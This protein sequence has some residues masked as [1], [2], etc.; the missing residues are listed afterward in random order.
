MA[1]ALCDRRSG[2]VCRVTGEQ[3]TVRF[4]IE[5]AVTRRVSGR[6]NHGMAGHVENRV[7]VMVPVSLSLVGLAAP[8]I[9]I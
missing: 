1:E 6:R 3:R 9:S 8:P 5:G 4:A 7:V 2:S